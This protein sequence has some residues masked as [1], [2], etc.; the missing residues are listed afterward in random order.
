MNVAETF[1]R[2]LTMRQ[3]AAYLVQHPM[4]L[5]SSFAHALSIITVNN[6]D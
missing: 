5:V 1:T 2:I 4:Q 3:R 6:K